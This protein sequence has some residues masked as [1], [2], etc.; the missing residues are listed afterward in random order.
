VGSLLFPGAG[1]KPVTSA[2]MPLPAHPPGRRLPGGSPRSL[3]WQAATANRGRSPGI[4]GFHVSRGS[5]GRLSLSVRPKGR[6][7]MRFSRVWFSLAVP[8]LPAMM[9]PAVAD[10]SDYIKGLQQLGAQFTRD[11]N[12]PGRPVVEVAWK[13]RQATDDRLKTLLALKGLAQVRILNLNG[14]GITDGA[15]V[16]LKKLDRLEELNLGNTAIADAG[17]G[18]LRQLR[19]LRTLFLGRGLKVTNQGVAEL[20]KAL[21]EVSIGYEYVVPRW[22]GPWPRFSPGRLYHGAIP[23]GR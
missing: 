13:R 15:L 23:P 12:M 19:S 21:P 16:H 2:R 1:R 3:T 20:Q 22:Y 7:R 11:E 17:L 4:L 8:L 5:R 14:A 9:P 10:E 18:H 6:W